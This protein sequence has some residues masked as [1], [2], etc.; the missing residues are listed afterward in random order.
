MTDVDVNHD[1]T[2]LF[3]LLIIIYWF[4]EGVTEVGLGLLKKEKRLT[5]LYIRTTIVMVLWIIMVGEYLRT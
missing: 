4:S 5:N 2:N 1:F 3:C